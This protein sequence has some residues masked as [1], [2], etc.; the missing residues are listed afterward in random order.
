[1]WEVWGWCAG[2]LGVGSPTPHRR[3]DIWPW[4]RV[5]C[6]GQRGPF[7]TS[8]QGSGISRL[9]HHPAENKPREQAVTS[10]LR[11][12]RA[13][14][15]QP[16]GPP[17]AQVCLRP[18]LQPDD[19]LSPEIQ[20][21]VRTIGDQLDALER[22]GVGLEQRLR[23]AEGGKLHPNPPPHPLGLTHPA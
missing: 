19:L 2:S 4:H 17:H 5:G 6:G 13:G 16:R 11:V 18:Q 15:G 10:P 22:R 12:S 8:P 21:Q 1:M 7:Q 20:R 9:T 14:G 23:A 3:Y